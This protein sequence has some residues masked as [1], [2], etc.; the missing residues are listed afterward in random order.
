LQQI[1]LYFKSSWKNVWTWYC[2]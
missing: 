1:C 2:E